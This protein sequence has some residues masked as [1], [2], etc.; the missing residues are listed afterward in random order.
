MVLH[1]LDCSQYIYA[2]ARSNSI[3]SRGV[4]E[5]NGEYQENWAPIGG[6]RFL[7]NQAAALSGPDSIVVPVFDRPPE[8][9]R[10][11]YKEAYGLEYGYKGK[12]K[13]PELA[14]SLQKKYAEEVLR[15]IGYPVQAAEQYECDD[16]LYTMVEMYKN[17]FEE[18]IVHCNDSDMY[19]LVGGNVSI[20]MVG[21][22]V[23]KVVTTASYPHVVDPK[24]WC[25]YNVHH[26]RKLCTGDSSDNIP[27]VGSH[28]T[29]LLD[30]VIPASELPNLGNLELCRSY[31]REALLKYPTAENAHALLSTF[32]I[33][34]PLQVPDYLINEVEPMIDLNKQR[35]FT[36]DWDESLDKWGFEDSLS[37]YIDSFYK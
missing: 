32:N 9:K 21:S 19:F 6:V 28:W 30:S 2:G 16:V 27:G 13:A 7:V 14:I 29:E 3:V 33:L 15:E 4:R 26:I 31:L 11:M 8:I 10:E 35:Y 23:G 37:A 25:P 34:V 5:T 36:S 22:K 20:G 24:G 1:L 17:D 18:I 12:R